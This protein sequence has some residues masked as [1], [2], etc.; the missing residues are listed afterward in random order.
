MKRIIALALI[1]G[2]A[3][4]D[5]ALAQVG[6]AGPGNGGPGGGGQEGPGAG[7]NG[8]VVLPIVGA[9]RPRPRPMVAPDEPVLFESCR[10]L[11]E[12]SAPCEHYSR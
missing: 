1:A 9:A 3:V 10:L 12:T 11:V 5:V 6:A 8:P 2:F 7:D 4:S